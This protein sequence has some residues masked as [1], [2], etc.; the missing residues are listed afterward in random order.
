LAN[1]NKK[2][3]GADLENSSANEKQGPTALTN[4]KL[5]N[6]DQVQAH[7]LIKWSGVRIKG[8]SE[9]LKPAVVLI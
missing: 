9:K 8:A 6:F 3:D 2:S 4:K 5:K 7:N 1:D